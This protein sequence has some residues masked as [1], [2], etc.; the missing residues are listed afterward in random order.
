MSCGRYFALDNVTIISEPQEERT[1]PTKAVLAV[2]QAHVKA[3]TRYTCALARSSP[4]ETHAAT[5]HQSGWNFADESVIT[6]LLHS[7][8]LHAS[9]LESSNR[10]GDAGQGITRKRNGDGIAA[11][12]SPAPKVQAQRRLAKR[13]KAQAQT[14]HRAQ[15]PC[16][17]RRYQ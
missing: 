12:S 4:D 9:M 10:T 1:T 5:V 16:M 7:R 17:R 6:G 2:R 8:L 13:P 3:G 15:C 14:L 11:V